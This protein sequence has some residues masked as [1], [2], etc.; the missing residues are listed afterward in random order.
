MG[1]GGGECEEGFV[2]DCSGDGDCCSESWIGDGYPDCED[3][4]WECDLTCYDNVGGDCAEGTDGGDDNG[5]YEC[6][7]CI[8]GIR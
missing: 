5:G 7:L 4:E 6:C 2:D 1:G 8:C 3:Q